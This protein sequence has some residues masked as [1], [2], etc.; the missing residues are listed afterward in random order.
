MGMADKKKSVLA[1]GRSWLPVFAGASPAVMIFLVLFAL[2]ATTVEGVGLVLVYPI[3]EIMRSGE[4][5]A[6]LAQKSEIFAYIVRAF[7]FCGLPVSL[8]SIMVMTVIMVIIRQGLTYGSAVNRA[9]FSY[10]AVAHISNRLFRSLLN[11]DLMVVEQHRTGT[12]INAVMV[13]CKRAAM[14]ALSS[15]NVLASLI[16][17]ALFGVLMLCL[18]WKAT[19]AGVIILGGVGFFISRRIIRRSRGLGSQMSS[20]NDALGRF[21]SERLRLFRL[22]KLARTE[23]VEQQLFSDKVHVLS[24]LNTDLT[25]SAARLTAL[26]EPLGVI[27]ALVALY[28]ASQML[29]MGLSEIGVFILIV[30]RLLPVMQELASNLQQAASYQSSLTYIAGI[31]DAAERATEQDDAPRDFPQSLKTGIRFENVSYLYPVSEEHNE[32]KPALEDISLLLPAGKTIALLGPSGAGKSTLIDLLPALK[33]PSS[34]RI[35]FDDVPANDIRLSSLRAH[36]AMVSQDILI[37]DGS[38]ED[39]LRYGNPSAT[40]EEIRQAARDACADGFIQALPEGYDSVLGERGARLSGGQR[41]R[42]ALA[43]AL[44]ARVPVLLLDEPTSALDAESELA[45]QQALERLQREHGTT[46]VII[47]H[48][49]STVSH[50]DLTVLL[51]K[52]RVVACGTHHELMETAPWYQKVVELQ[53]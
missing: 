36:I 4:E 18:S 45:V 17:L 52:G 23:T 37:I 53:S 20:I 2:L 39:N 43:R 50:A 15:L 51:D 14:L 5:P 24:D 38:V 34:G 46:I 48:R 40:A 16:K 25:R 29:G 3:L 31:I 7:E 33:R 27:I 41:Q 19:V 13:E 49:L 11:A 32:P 1:Q 10:D 21:T 6:M 9:Q 8:A 42:I 44:L 47:A 22:I 35:L 28:V 30:F 26:T 12:L